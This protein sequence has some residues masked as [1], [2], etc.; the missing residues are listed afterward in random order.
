MSPNEN[1]VKLVQRESERLGA[2][3]SDLNQSGLEQQSACEQWT[4]A[5]VVAHLIGGAQVFKEQTQRGLGG[6]A[7]PPDG[8]P[9]AGEADPSVM[10]SLN[11]HRTIFRRVGLGDNLY[12]PPFKQPTTN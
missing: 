5:D 9:A 6:D 4:V 7:A 11:A 3:L 1:Q 10:G 8:Y 2:Y 12:C